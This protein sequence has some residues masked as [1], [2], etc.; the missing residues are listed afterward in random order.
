MKKAAGQLPATIDNANI[1]IL[2]LNERKKN[3]FLLSDRKN[4]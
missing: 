3:F 2:F 4:G 1:D